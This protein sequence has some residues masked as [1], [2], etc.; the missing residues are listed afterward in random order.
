MEKYK[1]TL[2]GLT[3]DQY[4]YFKENIYNGVGS[5]DFALDP[6]DLIFKKAAEYHDFA[7]WRGGTEQDRKEADKRFKRDCVDAAWNQ[8][9]RSFLFYISAAYIYYY[10]VKFLGKYSFIYREEPLDNW[11]DLKEAFIKKTSK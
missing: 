7:Y 10:A 6:H 8:K 4:K 3:P 5:R 9:A 2:D 1:L 11:K